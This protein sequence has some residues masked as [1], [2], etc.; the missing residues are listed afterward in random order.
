MSTKLKYEIVAVNNIEV[1]ADV[2]MLQK[3]DELFF[4]AT[5]MSKQFGKKPN[6][7]LN[8]KQ[9]SEYIA[10]ILEAENFRYENLVRTTVGGKYQGTWLH[11]KLALPFSRWLSVKFE[12]HLDRWIENRVDDEHQ[13]QQHR[14]ELRTGFL[15]LTNA[16]QAAHP[17]LKPYHFSNECNLINRLVTGMDA[18]KFKQ[19]RGIENVRDGLTA[20]E[21]QLMDKLQMQNTCLIEL[22]FSYEDRKRRL[23][24]QADKFLG[25]IGEIAA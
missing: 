3:S 22:G 16:I 4:N 21:A 24:N 1:M 12:Y 6:E 23:Q 8:S 9:G 11:K 15:P 17:D 19:V 14:L 13:R 20:A 7:W 2:S 25:V 18:K 10:V 5:L